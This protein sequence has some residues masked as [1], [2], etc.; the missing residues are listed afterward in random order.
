ML[1]NFAISD[2]KI[3]FAI[4]QDHSLGVVIASSPNTWR[5]EVGA[6]LEEPMGSHRD[7]E[8]VTPLKMC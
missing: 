3:K 4:L 6:G 5:I 8:G 1:A 2:S 7:E